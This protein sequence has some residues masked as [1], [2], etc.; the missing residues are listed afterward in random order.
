MSRSRYDLQR[1]DQWTRNQPGRNRKASIK[2]C[3]QR[4]RCRP[5]TGSRAGCAGDRAAGPR[6]SSPRRACA[7]CAASPRGAACAAPRG[8]E[9]LLAALHCPRAALLGPAG[10]CCRPPSLHAHDSQCCLSVHASNHGKTPASPVCSA[11]TSGSAAAAEVA[12]LD[13]RRCSGLAASSL[14]SASMGHC[15]A[16]PHERMPSRRRRGGELDHEAGYSEIVPN[17]FLKVR[18][19]TW[20][21]VQAGGAG[22]SI[23]QIAH[24][25][26]PALTAVQRDGMLF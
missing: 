20:S 2:T 6:P 9:R 7:T 25:M 10:T 17:D 16:T 21:R 19:C 5:G 18:C 1:S 24:D 23:G 12:R 14:P 8:E 15:S 26:P 13:S 11:W 22:V 3:A 4:R